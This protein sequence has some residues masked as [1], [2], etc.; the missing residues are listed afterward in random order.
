[1]RLYRGLRE[2]YRADKAIALIRETGQGTDFTDCPFTALH[3]GSGRR[4]VVIVLDVPDDGPRVSEELFL[5]TG[6]QAK[7]LMVWGRFDAFIVAEIPARELRAEVRRKG[8][9]TMAFEVKR[10]ILERGIERHLELAARPAA[11]HG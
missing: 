6:Q 8:V 11:T 7:R 10:G 9:V 1:M 2:P 3:Y 4:G 5:G